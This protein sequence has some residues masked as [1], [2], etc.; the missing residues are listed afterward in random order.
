MKIV[1]G[2]LT[3]HGSSSCSFSLAWTLEVPASIYELASVDLNIT[4]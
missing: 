1:T 4:C 3:G 2:L